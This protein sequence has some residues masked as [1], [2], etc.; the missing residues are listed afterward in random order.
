[1]I[2]D[3][4]SVGA[5]FRLL[6]IRLCAYVCVRMHVC[7][8]GEGSGQKLWHTDYKGQISKHLEFGADIMID[9]THPEYMAHRH[10]IPE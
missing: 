6:N 2:G 4:N 7:V 9:V 3:M 10:F 8:G 5:K 1:M